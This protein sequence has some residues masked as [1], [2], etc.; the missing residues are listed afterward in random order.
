ME[1]VIILAKGY[2]PN[3][4]ISPLKLKEILKTVKVTIKTTNLD[5]YLYYDMG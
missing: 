3:L 2:L 1:A 4:L 5:L